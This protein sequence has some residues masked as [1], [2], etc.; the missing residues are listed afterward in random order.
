[1]LGT[2]KGRASTATM[3]RNRK[4]LS[5]EFA[6]A[7]GMSKTEESDGRDFAKSYDA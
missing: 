2:Q 4:V 6:T 1:M 5:P 3:S 7:R